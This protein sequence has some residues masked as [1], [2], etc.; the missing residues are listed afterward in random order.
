[1]L[2]HKAMQWKCQCQQAMLQFAD[3]W[4]TP[5]PAVTAKGEATSAQEI[6]CLIATKKQRLHSLPILSPLATEASWFHRVVEHSRLRAFVQFNWE[7][8]VNVYYFETRIISPRFC[9][10]TLYTC[11]DTKNRSVV[12]I[13][14]KHA[15]KE[16][17]FHIGHLEI[18]P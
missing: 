8:P 3:V 12:W 14:H 16:R 15:H 1:M 9:C 2:D 10:I 5:L 18:Y 7:N 6:A 13:L 4:S 11:S 17:T